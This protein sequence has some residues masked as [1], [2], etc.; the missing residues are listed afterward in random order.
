MPPQQ[1]TPW[2]APSS[3]LPTNY[4]STTAALFHAGMADPRGCDYRDIEIGTGNAW[5]G[6]GGVV[7]TR[8]WV[9]PGD[10]DRRF[11][12]CWNGLVYPAVTVGERA[13][14]RS[15]ARAAVQRAAQRWRSA[16]PE[17]FTVSHETC[18]PLKACL[19]LR[20]GEPR[21]AGELWAT[22]QRVLERDFGVPSAQFSSTNLSGVADFKLPG[23]DPYLDWAS[24]WAWGLFDRAVC[25]HMRGDDG[26]A[27]A[28]ARLLTAARPIIEIE[29]AHRGFKRPPSYNSGWN[30]NYQDYLTFLAPL[31]E[32]LTDQERRALERSSAPTKA[33]IAALTNQTERISALISELDEV[34]VRQFGQ[35]G[36]LAGWDSDQVVKGL[37]KEGPAAIEPLLQCLGSGR[38]D[39]LTRSVS[40]GRDFHRGRTLHP[41]SQP[42]V[43]ILVQLMNASYDAVG[44][45]RGTYAGISNAVLAARL[46]GYWKEFG[47]LPMPERWYRRLADDKAGAAAWGDALGNIV[48][49][50]K[51]ADGNPNQAGLAGEPLRAKTGPSVTELLVRRSEALEGS[52][53]PY[54]SFAVSDA[55]GFLLNSEKWEAAPLLPIAAELQGKVMDGY[56]GKQNIGSADPQNAG[57]IAT[58]AMLRA[59]HGDMRGLDEF[60]VWIQQADPRV[61]EDSALNAL[62]PF[63]RFPNHPAL[64]DTARGMF[65]STNSAWGSLAWLLEGHSHLRWDKALASPL[66]LIPEVR[67][68]VVSEL[69]NHTVGGEAVNRGG[70]NLEVTYSGTGTTRYGARKDLEGMEV[71]AKITFRRCDVVAEQL[72][73]IPG[74]PHMSLIWPEPRRDEAVA[75]TIKLLSTSGDCL[76]TREKPPGWSAAFGPP[77]VELKPDGK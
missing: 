16:L 2:A 13:D 3:S 68:L 1:A 8:G 14:W 24:E 63:W 59:R 49:P 30:E 69:T 45:S 51:P 50:V 54:N 48:R 39:R 18:L 26:L 64:R 31:P 21:L 43:D 10:G 46:R 77:L 27:L 52:A 75:A 71:G 17:A 29:A 57:S 34:A 60:A 56:A 67:A 65:G 55:A 25:A 74:F 41:V 37:L 70:G 20:L 61:L 11:A 28:S 4:V 73:A 58:L 9:L 44:L 12:V 36:G 33:D 22:L 7:K 72:S 76:Q 19:V 23:A 66:L 6:D 38:A 15:D 35:P 47:E 5:S 62:E 32:L 53:P 42:T 40:F